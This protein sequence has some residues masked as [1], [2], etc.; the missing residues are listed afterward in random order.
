MQKV[1]FHDLLLKAMD[2]EAA[3]LLAPTETEET[4]GG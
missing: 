1:G 4:E 2:F 3:G